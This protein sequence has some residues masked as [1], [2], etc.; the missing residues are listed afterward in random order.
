MLASV[1]PARCARCDFDDGTRGA[2]GPRACGCVPNGRVLPRTTEAIRSRGA[3]MTR[4]TPKAR[5]KK[6]TDRPVAKAATDKKRELLFEV[7]CEEI[8]AGMLERATDELKVGF[9]KQLAA[10]SI[11]DGVTVEAFST[12]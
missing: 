11:G 3:G 4:V 10:E 5:G 8:P 7:G 2:D 9:E 6:P 1:Q 12:P